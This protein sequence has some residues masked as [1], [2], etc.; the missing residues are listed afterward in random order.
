M[1][2]AAKQIYSE[3]VKES[4]GNEKANFTFYLDKKL[5]DQM[6]RKCK[7]DGISLSTVIENFFKDLL[8]K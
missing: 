3:T 7:A 8:G 2:K 4:K 5:T 6:K 1:A